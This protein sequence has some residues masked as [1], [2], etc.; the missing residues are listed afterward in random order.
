MHLHELGW[1]SFFE[2]CFAEFSD[3][4]VCPAR[5]VEEQ[6]GLY[7]VLTTHGPYLAEPAGKLRFHAGA[8][9]DLPAVGDWVVVTPRHSEARA[10]I[11]AVLPRRTTLSRKVAGRESVEQVIATN[12]DTVFIV[13]ALN[14]D[15]NLRRIERY[16]TL[17]W[18]SGARPVILLNKADL[19]SD[20]DAQ[21]AAVRH[22]ALGTEVHVIS[23]LRGTGLGHLQPHF[24]SGHTVALVGSS[25]VG[26]STL[27]NQLLGSPTLPVQPVRDHDDRGRHTTTSRE[28]IVLPLGGLL[29][30]TPGMRELQLLDN[31]DGVTQTF[32]DI[33]TLATQCH[34]RDCGHSAEPHCAVQ[35]ALR[36]GRLDLP[37]FENYRKLQAELRFQERKQNP[38]LEREQK[39]RWKK[40]HK[41]A[42]HLPKKF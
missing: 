36:S 19:S 5:V 9:A 29:I 13:S 25:G 20:P 15:F 7:R 28:M 32:A 14:R 33:E 39:E 8:H 11:D 34:Y 12:L 22:V 26:K 3:S 18:D 27:I 16:L 35:A 10:R 17:V 21:A 6:R 40:I 41:A 2:A 42:R 1:N 4:A 24:A 38:A 23:A 37:R 31:Q 30:D